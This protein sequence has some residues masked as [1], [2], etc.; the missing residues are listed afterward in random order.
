M[1][2]ELTDPELL[3]INEAADETPEESS[4]TY[5]TL[6]EARG[7]ISVHESLEPFRIAQT[8]TSVQQVDPRILAAKGRQA[9]YVRLP[10][11]MHSYLDDLSHRLMKTDRSASMTNLVAQAILEKYPD[12]MG[13]TKEDTPTDP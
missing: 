2:P 9:L 11:E 7:N 1:E 10:V 3:D 4:E 13:P 8:E 5:A 12:A 6:P